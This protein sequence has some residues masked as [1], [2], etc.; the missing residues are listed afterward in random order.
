M[1]CGDVGRIVEKGKLGTWETYCDREVSDQVVDIWMQWLRSIL[2]LGK[3]VDVLQ[4]RE[5]VGKKPWIGVGR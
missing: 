1:V 4:V 3:G 2:A 5:I